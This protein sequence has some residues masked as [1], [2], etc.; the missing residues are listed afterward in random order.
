MI[1]LL[2]VGHV[3]D[4][5]GAIRGEIIARRPR[6]VALELDSVRYQALM[7]RMPRARGI[8]P[9]SLLAQFQVRIARQ[10]GVEVGDEM[11]AAARAAQEIGSEI[12]LID[13]DSR[14]VLGRVWR[15]MSFR[16]RVRLLV[17]TV[18][19]F[20]TRREKVEAELQRFY[21]DEH[22]FLQEFARELPTAKRI[23]I[24]ERDA[25]MASALRQLE[26]AKGDVVAVVGE[27]HVD[28]LLQILAGTA[29]QVVHL[30]QL[31]SAPSH[32]NASVNVSV[33]L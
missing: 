31:R 14:T 2:G 25:S 1:T 20:L 16:E 7:S 30:Q 12:A 15:E 21:Q 19:G 10:Y 24:D 6:V 28:G 13:Q 27:G 8:S 33:Q 18:G 26:Q 4:I 29:T 17:S 32:P 5:G 3:F 9:L 22:S 23:L 11:V